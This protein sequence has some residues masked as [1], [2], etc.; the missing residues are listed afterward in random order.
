MKRKYILIFFI[1]IIFIFVSGLYLK[2]MENKKSNNFYEENKDAI[3]N[4]AEKIAIVEGD[5]AWYYQFLI[6]TFDNGETT[7][8]FFNG[9]SLKYSKLDDYYVPVTENGKVVEKIIVHPNLVASQKSVNNVTE[10]SEVVLIDDFFDQKQFKKE[11]TTNDLDELTL[12]NFD[13]NLI[14]DLFNKTY[15][16]NF[17]KTITKFNLAGCSIQSD[18]EKDGY[19]Y[20]IGVMHLR[21]GIGAIRIDLLYNDGTY[22]SELIENKKA[23]NE[24]KEIYKNF[25]KIEEY[26]VENQEVN[27]RDE[28]D[29]NKDVY[30]RLFDIIEKFDDPYE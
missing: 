29:L 2:N 12:Y 14:V 1:S 10:A 8:N 25:K 21:R 28:F 22:L 23:S 15:N 26:I 19:K 24:Q 20:N 30:N 13:K 18:G 6:T 17:D 27:I 5:D 16:S 9:C 7:N 4:Y 11:I 3:E